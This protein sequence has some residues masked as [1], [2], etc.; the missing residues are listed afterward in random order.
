[1][2]S[3]HLL[4]SIII[5]VSLIPF[6][7]FAA[8]NDATLTAD[9]VISVGGY[10]LNIVGSSAVVESIT[11]NESDFSVTLGSGSSVTISSPTLN[12]LVPGS[13]SGISSK[14]CTSSAS[15]ITFSYSGVGTITNTITPSATKCTDTSPSPTPIPTP[16]TTSVS[17]GGGNSASSQVS[18]LLAMGQYAL[19]LQIAKQY[20]ITI[21]ANLITQGSTKIPVTSLLFTRALKL[22]MTGAD[23][24]RLQIFLNSQGFT[25][26]KKGAG[27]PG[28]ETTTFGSA[29]KAAL[30]KF[31]IVHKKEI[32]D[33]QGLKSPT[34][35]FASGSMKIANA[36]LK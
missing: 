11:I 6:F 17:S 10:T 2:R 9:A 33:P 8:Y 13:Q 26:A 30:M 7:S 5:S 16:I 19:A 3:Y 35:I 1:M 25:V 21:P 20:G 4:I 36:L 22:G 15:S 14:I 18:N 12:M 32:L 34:G 29:T 23:I 28:H 27:S 31:Q 24:K